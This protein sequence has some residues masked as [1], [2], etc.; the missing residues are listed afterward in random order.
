[1]GLLKTCNDLLERFSG[2]RL[3]RPTEEPFPSGPGGSLWDFRS[4][5]GSLPEESQDFIRFA[6]P[7]LLDSHAQ[8]L[9]DLWV[10][11]ETVG[12]RNGFFVEF[13]ATDGISIN[14]S[15]LLEREYG[16]TGILAE[17]NPACHE[18]LR[19]K[20][21]ATVDARAVW[22]STGHSVELVVPGNSD[23]AT[24]RDY[25]GADALGAARVGHDSVTVETVSLKDLLDEH[26]APQVI[27]FLSIDTEGSELDILSAYDFSRPIR[28]I[29]VEHNYSGNRDALRALLAARGYVRRHPELSEVDDWYR[30]Q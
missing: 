11:H 23:L 15:L 1:M 30:Q 24:L 22:V 29:C 7:R 17:P 5:L 10:L 25:A 12:Q 9:Q 8:F 26:E 28:L 27:D 18:S 13:G 14:N 21:R 4:H 3:V 19:T 2:R 6:I 20:R 16:W